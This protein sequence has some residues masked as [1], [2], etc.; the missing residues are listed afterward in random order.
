M[1]Q[2]AGIPD[3]VVNILTTHKNVVPIGKEICES[4]TVKKIS[5]TGSTPV[6]KLLYGLGS[7]TLKK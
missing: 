3:G 1:A 5:F 2:R 6:A 7:T 4:R